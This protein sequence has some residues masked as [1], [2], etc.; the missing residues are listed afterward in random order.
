MYFAIFLT[1]P[2]A[3]LYQKLWRCQKTAPISESLS[4]ALHFYLRYNSIASLLSHEDDNTIG[5]DEKIIFYQ[6]SYKVQ[7]GQ[8]FHKSLK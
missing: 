1:N 5:S 2:D 7:K 4:N 3:K 6:E 8:L